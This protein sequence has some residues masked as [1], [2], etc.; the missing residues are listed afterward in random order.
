[1]VDG[2]I[3][4][5]A[6]AAKIAEVAKSKFDRIDALVNTRHLFLEALHGFIRSTICALSFPSTSKVFLF[7]KPARDQADVGSEDGGSIVN[8]TTTMADHPNRRIN[9]AGSIITKGG[10]EASREPGDEIRET[11]IRVNAVAAGHRRY[12]IA[13]G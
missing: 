5:A 2:S 1:V 7:I 12:T 6:T 8:I 11:G 4:E 13:Q 9:S 10:L 3:A